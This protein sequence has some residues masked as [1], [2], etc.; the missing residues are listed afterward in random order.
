MHPKT[1]RKDEIAAILGDSRD[2]L[3][4]Q[5]SRVLSLLAQY[6]DGQDEGMAGA[7]AQALDGLA[8]SLRKHMVLRRRVLEAI[9]EDHPVVQ[10][11]SAE[12]GR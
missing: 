8:A 10:F 1:E 4:S 5:T 9:A 7:T 11:P 3:R 12:E 2:G 6:L